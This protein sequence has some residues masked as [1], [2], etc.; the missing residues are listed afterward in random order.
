M[1]GPET[2]VSSKTPSSVLCWFVMSRCFSRGTC[3]NS[4]M[5]R[6]AGN[7][8]KRAKTI[9]MLGIRR[10]ALHKDAKACALW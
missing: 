9:R 2:F 7:E 3:P 8:H 6:L 10:E 4:F 1:R 5:V